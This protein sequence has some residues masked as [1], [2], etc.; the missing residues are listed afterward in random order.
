MVY[1]CRYFWDLRPIWV[2]IGGYGN[3][4]INI[5]PGTFSGKVQQA[6]N[7]VSKLETGF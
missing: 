4:R 6:K 5:D 1:F 2:R 7:P 3:F